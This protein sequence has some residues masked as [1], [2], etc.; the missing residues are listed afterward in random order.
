MPTTEAN[1]WFWGE[2][3]A[4]PQHGAE[5]SEPWGGPTMQWQASILPRIHTFLPAPCI[6]EIAP[7]FGRWTHFLKDLCAQLITVDL[8]PR[9]IQHC[10]ERFKDCAHIR[11]HVNDGRSLAMISDVSV[12]F[13]FSYDSLVHVE[14][15]VMEA[16]VAQL[17]R[18]LKPDGV[19]FLHHS[20]LGEYTR[21]EKLSAHPKVSRVL[22]KVMLIESHHNRA[23]SMTAELMAQSCRRNGLRCVVQEKTNWRTRRILTDCFSTIMREGPSCPAERP[24][25][26]NPRFMQEA[27][28][29]QRLSQSYPFPARQLRDGREDPLP[30]GGA[31]SHAGRCGGERSHP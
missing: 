4:W 9:C 25:I 7:G 28:L 21:F 17:A 22:W 2:G 10:R 23:C 3:Y 20:N 13:V 18:I 1:K 14:R 30:A 31:P 24:A 16:Y 26:R 27:H 8:A 29:I 5:W 6:L 11:Y 19:A 15:D 12:D